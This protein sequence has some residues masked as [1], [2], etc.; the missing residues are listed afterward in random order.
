MS[1]QKAKARRVHFAL[2]FLGVTVNSGQPAWWECRELAGHI[3]SSLRKQ[4]EKRKEESG[5]K[6]SLLFLQRGS[7]ALPRQH[8]Q[9]GTPPARDTPHSNLRTSFSPV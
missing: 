3:V 6:V 9:L 4:R 7:T 5:P 2:E 1:G 8:H